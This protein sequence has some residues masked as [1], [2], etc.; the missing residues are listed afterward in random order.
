MLEDSNLVDAMLNRQLVESL[1][2]LTTRIDL[3][4]F[5]R[6]RFTIYSKV[7]KTF[8]GMK[9]N[10]EAFEGNIVIWT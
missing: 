6:D 2:Y 3:S 8:N 4:Y 5:C 1:I 7:P 10:T 9:K